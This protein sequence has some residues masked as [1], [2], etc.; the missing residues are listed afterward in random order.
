MVGL[1]DFVVLYLSVCAFSF[2][3]GI[4]QL[5]I[6][7]ISIPKGII[8]WFSSFRFYALEIICCEYFGCG[9]NLFAIEIFSN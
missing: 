6:F 9:F 7:Y 3:F 5:S 2:F 1:D 8:G 4:I